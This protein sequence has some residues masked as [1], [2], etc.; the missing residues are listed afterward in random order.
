MSYIAKLDDKTTNN[1]EDIYNSL[2]QKFRRGE[3]EKKTSKLEIVRT[4]I[5]GLYDLMVESGEING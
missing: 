4:L 3:L 1:L 5:N 2:Y